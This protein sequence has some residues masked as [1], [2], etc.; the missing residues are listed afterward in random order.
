[1]GVLVTKGIKG[2]PNVQVNIENGY[3]LKK[4]AQ[5]LPVTGG[6]TQVLM[7]LGILTN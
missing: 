4:I 5:N 6:G 1:M 2:S 3:V 7:Q